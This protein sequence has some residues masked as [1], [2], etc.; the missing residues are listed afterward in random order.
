V[1]S[2]TA[3]K[4]ASCASFEKIRFWAPRHPHL[5]DKTVASRFAGQVCGDKDVE[6][7]ETVSHAKSS[8]ATAIHK[9]V[10]YHRDNN[11]PHTTLRPPSSLSAKDSVK[12]K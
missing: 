7:L 4:L 2:L 12:N 8:P 6:L 9:S 5:I 1:F 11:I 3:Y 10:W